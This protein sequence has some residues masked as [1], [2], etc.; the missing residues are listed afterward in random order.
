MRTRVSIGKN[1][2]QRCLSL[3]QNLNLREESSFTAHELAFAFAFSIT[4]NVNENA[5]NENYSLEVELHLR[6][7]LLLSFNL[8]WVPRPIHSSSLSE[9]V[10][11]LGLDAPEQI[12]TRLDE[13]W[14]E[15]SCSILA[16]WLF[17]NEQHDFNDS[18][19]SLCEWEN[20]YAGQ[21]LPC[22][23]VAP[24]CCISVYI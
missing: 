22:F 12:R 4:G 17:A 15:S 14:L 23:D 16:S 6:M 24:C 11:N 20:P 3:S 9:M 19:S 5:G 21:P 13:P 1:F 2:H 8:I 7:N 10:G 18:I